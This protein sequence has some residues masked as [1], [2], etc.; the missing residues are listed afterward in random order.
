M[1]ERTNLIIDK[2]KLNKFQNSNILL[3]GVGGVGG[4]TFEALVRMGIKNITIIDND[5]FTESNLNRQI[6][7]NRSNI[8]NSKV[9]EAYLRGVSINP[10][11]H[12]K[13]YEMFLNE[14]NF[15][16]IEID[17]Y[18]YIIDCCDT[19]T[20]KVLLIKIAILNNIKIISSMGTGNRIDPT[21]LVIKDI[22]KTSYDP[23]AKVIRKLLRDNNINNHIPVLVSEEK[24]IKISSR[25][26]G[27]TS[28]ALNSN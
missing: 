3:I 6:L 26:P 19:I 18:D 24:P 17:K 10:D 15:K 25:I 22:W 20:T 16:E 9:K 23:L 28:F 11:I 1:D 7:C 5:Y 4:A 14:A 8:G 2:D 12:I 21:K 27:S 13:M